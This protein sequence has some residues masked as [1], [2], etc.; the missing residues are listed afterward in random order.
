MFLRLQMCCIGQK[1]I[2]A[3]ESI[4]NLKVSSNKPMLS[5]VIKLHNL[6]HTGPDG[7][8]TLKR[9]PCTML[10]QCRVQIPKIGFPNIQSRQI[11][12]C[13]HL[14][15]PDKSCLRKLLCTIRFIKEFI[16]CCKLI[17]L[18]YF[19]TIPTTP[20]NIRLL[21]SVVPVG[22]GHVSHMWLLVDG[23]SKAYT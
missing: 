2:L 19:S 11:L 16:V 13:S 6:W 3:P 8:A 4:G 23:F 21:P 1:T 22:T 5:T 15:S 20:L 18:L 17:L 7:M 14:L 9:F 12:F 10:V